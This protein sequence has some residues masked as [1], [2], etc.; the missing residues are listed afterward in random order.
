MYSLGN[1]R[2]FRTREMMRLPPGT[3]DLWRD[4]RTVYYTLDHRNQRQSKADQRAMHMKASSY[5]IQRKNLHW[6]RSCS[7]IHLQETIQQWHPCCGCDGDTENQHILRAISIF[8]AYGPCTEPLFGS[9][10]VSHAER[11]QKTFTACA[12]EGAYACNS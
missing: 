3:C 2:R 7:F 1:M 8:L 11:A 12:W 5:L 6:L 10:R 4:Y 9:M